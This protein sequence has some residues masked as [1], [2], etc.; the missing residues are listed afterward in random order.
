MARA[1]R[2]NL[3]IKDT[4]HPTDGLK[5]PVIAHLLVDVE[6]GGRWRIKTG[7][8]LVYNDQKLHLP[9]LLDELLL[10]F[11]LKRFWVFAA[12]HLI[13]Y[14]VPFQLLGHSFASFLALDI[15]W[16]RFVRRNDSAPVKSLGDDQFIEF[17]CLIDATRHKHGIA[18][19]ALQAIFRL[20]VQQDV[21]DNHCQS[22]L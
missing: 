5:E 1:R 9:W 4:V 8:E 10:N 6:I 17:T 11:F 15:R 21:I 16:R 3:K 20:H 2:P 14:V 22:R 18:S 7:Q 12:E 13:V 19:T